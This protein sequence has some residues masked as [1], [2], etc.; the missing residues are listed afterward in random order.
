VVLKLRFDESRISDLAAEYERGQKR[1]L[2]ELEESFL[3]RRD[4][5]IAR[6]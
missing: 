6:G 4:E 1:P 5:V 3:N 2:L